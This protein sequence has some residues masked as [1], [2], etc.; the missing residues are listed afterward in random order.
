MSGSERARGKLWSAELGMRNSELKT[1]THAKDAKGAKGSD[2][3]G[4]DVLVFA[5][6]AFLS[7]R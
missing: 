7:E 1:F 6:L 5:F 4:K 2:S 3:E